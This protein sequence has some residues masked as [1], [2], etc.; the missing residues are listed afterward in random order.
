MV[1]GDATVTAAGI[2]GGPFYGA[3]RTPA[4]GA[5]PRRGRDRQCWTCGP[6]CR[7]LP[8]RPG[9][10]SRVARLSLSSFLRKAVGLPP[11]SV[12]LLRE[13]GV[14]VEAIRSLTLV[15]TGTTGLDRAIS[16]AGGVSASTLLEGGMLPAR[17]GMPP[18]VFEGAAAEMLDWEAPTV[19]ATVLQAAFSTGF[20]AGEAALGW[21]GR[22]T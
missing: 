4:R 15:L 10:H 9:W 18:G 11:V 17:R 16:T 5:G 8:W 2:E 12:A 19:L 21:L 22:T 1:P 6:T 3:G 20:A 14:G 13:R 7:P